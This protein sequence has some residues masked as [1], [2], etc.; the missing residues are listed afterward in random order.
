VNC[1]IAVFFV[2]IKRYCLFDETVNY[3]SM[4]LGRCLLK[5][6]QKCGILLVGY[7]FKP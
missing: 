5:K 3:L 1:D 2:I 6:S 4:Q 7:K